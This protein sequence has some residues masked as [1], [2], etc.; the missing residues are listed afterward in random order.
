[1][2]E[3]VK[4]HWEIFKTM[5][6]IMAA[7]C[8]KYPDINFEVIYK[9]LLSMQNNQTDLSGRQPKL[10]RGQFE[11]LFIR[12]TRNDKEAGLA[13][14]MGRGEMME[15]FARYSQQAFKSRDHVANFTRFIE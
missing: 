3:L 10:N 6:K 2:H 8:N 15:I 12:S 13:S 9:Y 11:L 7:E 1:M 5:Q 14:F 4:T